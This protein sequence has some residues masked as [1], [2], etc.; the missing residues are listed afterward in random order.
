MAPSVQSHCGWWL[1]PCWWKSQRFCERLTRV[2]RNHAV[3]RR[4]I[5]HHHGSGCTLRQQLTDAGAWL[6]PAW[7]SHRHPLRA[8]SPSLETRMQVND[9]VKI[10]LYTCMDRIYFSKCSR[11][12]LLCQWLSIVRFDYVS[13]VGNILIWLS[14]LMSYRRFY[15]FHGVFL[16]TTLTDLFHLL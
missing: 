13:V 6:C 5:V 4:V 11:P 1:A 12:L 8:F 9:I 7:G 3:T 10:I 14:V 16:L 2:C 15:I